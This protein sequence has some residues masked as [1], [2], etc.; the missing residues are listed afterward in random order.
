MMNKLTRQD[1]M[2]AFQ[3]DNAPAALLREAIKDYCETDN[4]STAAALAQID[5][6]GNDEGGMCGR[7]GGVNVYQDRNGIETVEYTTSSES[8]WLHFGAI[9]E[10]ALSPCP[11]A[12]PSW[13]DDDWTFGAEG[14]TSIER[15]CEREQQEL[16]EKWGDK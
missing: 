6:S 4:C 13:W 10:Q 8:A 3:L 9:V 1:L 14:K 16:K 7:W 11:N 5:I 2:K 12:R 15:D